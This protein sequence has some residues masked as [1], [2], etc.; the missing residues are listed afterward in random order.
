M[1]G[2]FLGTSHATLPVSCH[3]FQ[4]GRPTKTQGDL[5]GRFQLSQNWFLGTTAVGRGM[6]SSPLPKET[7]E[8]WG[9]A[10]C[11]WQPGGGR[12]VPAPRSPDPSLLVPCSCKN[13]EWSRQSEG[14]H[15]AGQW[16]PVPL[17]PHPQNPTKEVPRDS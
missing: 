11:L 2:V 14:R 7:T 6:L 8:G 16:V 1:P 17:L 5:G 13:T 12:T 3:V 4:K 10:P 15:G 9:Q